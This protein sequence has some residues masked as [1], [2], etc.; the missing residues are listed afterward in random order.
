MAFLNQIGRSAS[1]FIGI[2]APKPERERFF[3]L[4]ILVSAGVMATATI[5]LF[6]IMT[7]IM[8]R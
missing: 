3:G 6:F 2:T 8:L 4:L 1:I 5:A 7:R